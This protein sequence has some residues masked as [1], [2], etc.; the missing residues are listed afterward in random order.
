M[1]P[2]Y[3][4]LKSVITLL[5]ITVGNSLQTIKMGTNKINIYKIEMACKT[6]PKMFVEKLLGQSIIIWRYGTN[7]TPYFDY[8]ENVGLQIPN[9]GWYSK[10]VGILRATHVLLQFSQPRPKIRLLLCFDRSRGQHF[11]CD[12]NLKIIKN[13]WTLTPPSD[14]AIP[15]KKFPDC[16]S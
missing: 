7:I 6:S 1:G 5:L 15:T 8:I 14:D 11:W 3:I 12:R 13:H 4:F 10:N 9:L 16:R 2:T